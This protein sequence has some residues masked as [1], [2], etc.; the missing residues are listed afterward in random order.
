M[1]VSFSCLNPFNYRLTCRSGSVATLF[2]AL[3]A[4]GL[5]AGIFS[6]LALNGVDMASFN[7]LNLGN[8]A[9]YALIGASG[10]FFAIISVWWLTKLKESKTVSNALVIEIPQN[11]NEHFLNLQK[12]CME[13]RMLLEQ[14]GLTPFNF[15][16]DLVIPVCNEG[17]N[18]S[19][20][21]YG[22]LKM[23][24]PELTVLPPH[25]A[26]GGFDPGDRLNWAA[27][28][29]FVDWQQQN[30]QIKSVGYRM[31]FGI[32]RP[33]AFGADKCRELNFPFGT[34]EWI[35]YC[36]LKA[37]RFY[38]TE[39]PKKQSIDQA[40]EEKNDAKAAKLKAWMD[41][42]LFCLQENSPGKRVIFIPLTKI[43]HEEVTKR[44]AQLEGR[45]TV[46]Q[47]V[48]YDDNLNR[49]K[50]TKKVAKQCEK[51]A[52]QFLSDLVAGKIFR[53]DN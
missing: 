50:T 35:Y 3:S 30:E 29:G 22:V 8:P 4:I 10:T 48:D 32:D 18:R 7:A 19:A 36:G 43:A 41:Q 33:E 13:A 23:L 24:Y 49:K 11:N 9:T 5:L 14:R 15:E 6:V 20:I 12:K 34:Q 27:F 2:I 28:A 53:F 38:D 52:T 17:K 25:G 16:T 37:Q 31:A 51:L 26:V 42:H 44:L 46:T 21:I 39:P 40:N 45:A 47:M 1:E